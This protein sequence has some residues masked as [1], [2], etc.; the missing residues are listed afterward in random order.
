MDQER[1][2]W[3]EAVALVLVRYVACALYSTPALDA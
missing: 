3:R 1:T 2:G